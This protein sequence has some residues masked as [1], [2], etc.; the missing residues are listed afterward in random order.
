MRVQ[1]GAAAVQM[2]VQQNALQSN[3]IASAESK[4]DESEQILIR[5]SQVSQF[6]GNKNFQNQANVWVDADYSERSRMPERRLQFGTSEYFDLIKKEPGLAQFFALGE[7]V[8]VVWKNTVY[9][10]T[11]Q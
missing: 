6:V 8:L 7:E 9:R 11:K 3:V 4:K 5:N 1:S 10:V 2:S